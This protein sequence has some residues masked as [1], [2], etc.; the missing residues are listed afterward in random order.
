MAKLLFWT[1][2]LTNTLNK[3]KLKWTNKV[4]R[5]PHH[6]FSSTSP[7]IPLP[8]RQNTGSVNSR[9]QS[10]SPCVA[11][12]SASSGEDIEREIV[13]SSSVDPQAPLEERE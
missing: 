9:A 4:G 13:K 2:L 3:E 1:S 12:T 5:V 6:F 10:Q 11:G 8:K 7:F